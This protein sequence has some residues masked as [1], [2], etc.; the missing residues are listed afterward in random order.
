MAG[1][2][3]DAHTELDY[4]QDGWI[5]G[6]HRFLQSVDGAIK[7]M[8]DASP[9]TYRRYEDAHLMDLF[10]VHGI[11]TRELR[12]LNLC[13]LYLQVDRLSDITN[14]A[15]TYIYEQAI[16][17]DR[18]TQTTEISASRLAWPR[19]PRP[20]AKAR[21]LWKKHLHTTLLQEDGRLRFPL[22]KWDT[23]VDNRDRT[24]RT[25]YH[26]Y[27][28]TIHQHD[29]RVY[30]SFPIQQ[31]NRR[32]I[33]AD[34]V[35]SPIASVSP[36]GYPVDVKSIQDRVLT[37]KYQ[38][39]NTITTRTRQL[40]QHPRFGALPDWEADLMRHTTIY[41]Q[42]TPLLNTEEILLVTD[43]GVEGGRGYFGTVLAAER[44]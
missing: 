25:L 9:Q 33:Q 32:Y 43:G 10:R 44:Q 11:T 31:I 29:G 34:I 8:D 40:Q 36:P 28:N 39:R 7:F 6:I 15:G 13:R 4:V 18:E 27:S 37:A 1:I 3:K 14:M 24:Y 30:R 41:E 19:T 22:G 42:H 38:V 26:P 35:D 2:L 12:I 5:M 16:Q 21:K 20:E 17:L 23:T